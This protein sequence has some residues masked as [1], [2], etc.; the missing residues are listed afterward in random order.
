LGFN[1]KTATFL[2]L[3]VFFACLLFVQSSLLH[4]QQKVPEVLGLE[5]DVNVS[6]YIRV[7]SLQFRVFPEKR[8]PRIGNWATFIDL[9]LV[10]CSNPAKFY[11][12]TNI[13]T[14]S[15]GYGTVIFPNTVY[16]LDGTY[17]LYARGFSHL[18]RSFN[19]Y[20]IDQL[21]TFID[22]TLE[23]KELFAGETSI[24]YDNYINSLDM[25]VL[26]KKLFTNDYQS[27]LNQDTKVN[28]LDFANQIYN[29]FMFG[30]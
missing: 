10:N 29:L 23:G 14:D 4:P 7:T 20:N 11:T 1:Y 13:P 27:D 18:N 9:R 12:F 16:T 15:L 25:S 17:R 8:I 24:S 26:I 21:N 22:L 28:S 2:A 5:D 6:G 19:C 3:L 30:N